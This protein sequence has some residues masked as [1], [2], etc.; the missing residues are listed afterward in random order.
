MKGVCLPTPCAKVLP[1][2]GVSFMLS[3]TLKAVEDCFHLTSGY[4][5]TLYD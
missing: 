1:Y 2:P 5:D 4:A 3:S